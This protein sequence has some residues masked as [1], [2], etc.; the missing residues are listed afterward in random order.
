MG[1]AAVRGAD[2]VYVTDDD[3]HDE[4]PAKVRAE[5]LAGT[6]PNTGSNDG[7]PDRRCGGRRRLAY[8]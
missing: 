1:A 4:D 2:V 7:R 5:V 6:G 3:P 8:G